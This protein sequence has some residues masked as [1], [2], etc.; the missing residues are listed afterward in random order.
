MEDLEYR[1][2]YGHDPRARSAFNDLILAIHGL[3]F[4]R[5]VE[6]V[7]WDPDFVLFSW[8]RGDEVVA[9][10]AIYSVDLRL[11]GAWVRTAQISSVGTRPAWRRRGLN[12]ELTRRARAW[13][14]SRGHRGTFLFSD[15]DAVGFYA[16]QGFEERPEWIHD[17]AVSSATRPGARAVEYDAEEDRIRRLVASRTPVSHQLGARCEKLVLFHLLYG[18]AGDLRYVDDLDLL[19]AS[20]REG[21]QLHV[22]DLI[23]PELPPWR[24]IEP[25]VVEDGIETVRFWIT[26]DRLDL[27]DP[28]PREERG[29]RLHVGKGE[30]LFP[31]RG[32]V[33][34]TAHA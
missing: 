11:G 32:I 12:A 14:A 21:D 22:Y 15:D 27:T 2:D 17:V 29:S 3:D 25:Y 30:A 16:K 7:G 4:T 20:E 13:A 24:E 33:P 8:F 10:T 34:P 31:S 1:E 28:Q 9:G 6:R 5:W 26:P 18:N 23:G 19:V